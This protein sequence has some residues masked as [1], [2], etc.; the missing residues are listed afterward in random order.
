M[1]IA[2]TDV[3]PKITPTTVT[4]RS[5]FARKTTRSKVCIRMTYVHFSTGVVIS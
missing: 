5:I 2:S 3:E 4:V 1:I